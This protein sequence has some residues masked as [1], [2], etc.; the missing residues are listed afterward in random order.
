VSSSAITATSATITWNTNEN[1]DSQ[2][3]YGT[4]VSYGQ[5]ST[6]N[7]SMVTFH[8]VTLSSLS[9]ATTYHFMVNSRDTFGNLATSTDNTFITSLLPDTTAPSVPAALTAI[10]ASS[11]QINLSWATSTDPIVSGQVTS[12]LAGYKI[13]RGGVQIATSTVN[14]YSNTGLTA[15]TTYT[16]TVLAFDGAGNNS[17]QS[18]ST[19]ATTPG[20]GGGL[21]L[22]LVQ[23]KVAASGANSNQI[24]ITVTSTGAGR[25]LVVGTGNNGGRTVTGVSDG[26]NNFTRATNAAA[27]TG[28]LRTDIWYLLNSSSGKT[29]I[30]VTY[31]GTA[32]TFLKIGN[33]WEVS[34][35][36]A[37]AFDT[38]NN[39]NGVGSGTTDT[40]A[41]VTT[42][43]A[44]GFVV[45][46]IITPASIA[47]NPKAGN[48]FTAGGDISPSGNDGAGASLIS[49]T[50]A[51]HTPVWLD[52]ASGRNFMSSTAAFK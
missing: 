32:G 14:S 47:Q 24:T 35:F 38:A 7:S 52:L 51:S 39:I 43:A 18:T 12:G 15:S 28:S 34:G 11:S 45:G 27:G 17:G 41:T 33:V 9:A 44:K 6:L 22:V 13:F 29:T 30:T 23:H 46:E 26:T 40:G 42:T 25:L 3:N 31:S 8:S 5:S 50:A 19:S 4:T 48:E 36:T 2:V 20:S 49:G 21:P 10:A 1:S 16:F 37:A